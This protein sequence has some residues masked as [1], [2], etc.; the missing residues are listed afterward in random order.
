MSGRNCAYKTCIITRSQYFWNSCKHVLNTRATVPSAV[1]WTVCRSYISICTKFWL[2]KADHS[3]TTTGSGQTSDFFL[4]ELNLRFAGNSQS[5]Y[6]A[7]AWLLRQFQVDWLLLPANITH[8]SSLLMS[9][10]RC[11][12]YKCRGS[13]WHICGP[14]VLTLSS[15]LFYIPPFG[16]AILLVSCKTRAQQLLRW[17]TVWSQ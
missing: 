11:Q 15:F 17:A 1:F 5:F 12:I 3:S 8:N 2:P 6:F 13:V 16:D 14:E 7:S 9:N 10:P 4:A